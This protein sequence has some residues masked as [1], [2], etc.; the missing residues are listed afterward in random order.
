LVWNTRRTAGLVAAAAA[1]LLLLEA[2]A[3]EAVALAMALAPNALASEP[4]SGVGFAPSGELAARGVERFEVVAGAPPARLV[5]WLVEPR[6]AA[7]GTIVLLH[8]VRSDRRSL[9][10]MGNVLADAGYRSLLV[11]LRGH[12]ESSGR[13]LTYGELEAADVSAM[14]DALDGREALGCVGAYGFS[15]GASVA[16]ELAARDARL[17]AVVAVAPF[18]S[19]REVVLDYRERY[20]PFPFRLLPDVWFEQA[21]NQASELGSF[22]P[23]MNAPV[24]LVARS[25]AQQLLIHGTSDTQVPLRHS[26]ELARAAG[27]RATVLTVD[28]ASHDDLPF[29]V[30][31]RAALSWY[32]RWL[33]QPECAER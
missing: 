17:K 25:R 6:A 22:D 4:P 18:A 23:D 26:R 30:L 5:S 11:D 14:L 29:R 2:G 33:P 3:R 32:E 8:G 7:L 13:Y 20:L 16:L 31:A 24:Q 27:S 21:V 12:G 19:L 15:Y 1:A 9:V 28:G 10:D